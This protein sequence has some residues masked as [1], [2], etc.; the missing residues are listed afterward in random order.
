MCPAISSS[1]AMMGELGL[2]ASA[3]AVAAY[4]G[5]LIDGFVY[6]QQDAGMAAEDGLALLCTDT[7]MS[8]AGERERLARE[9][10]TLAAEL[11]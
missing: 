7:I 6:D 2:E 9:V 8:G 4:Y 1:P 5:H 11:T 3:A 10:L